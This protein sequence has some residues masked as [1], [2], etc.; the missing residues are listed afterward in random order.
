M[1]QQT[2][3]FA[4]EKGVQIAHQTFDG[5]QVI[6]LYEGV[7][8]YQ[9]QAQADAP[10]RGA[11]A[12]WKDR[13]RS[14]QKELADV[15]YLDA[16][17]PVMSP[18]MKLL[19]MR[20]THAREYYLWGRFGR[21]FTARDL[22]GHSLQHHYLVLDDGKFTA[23]LQA[24]LEGEF[25]AHNPNPTKSIAAV[26]SNFMSDRGLTWSQAGGLARTRAGRKQK[27]YDRK[28]YY[29]H[30]N[31]LAQRRIANRERL[32]FLASLQRFKEPVLEDTD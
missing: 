32:A 2:E 26:F 9:L 10:R 21:K 11:S 16:R 4:I 25:W 12:G 19:L 14:Y 13:F 30:T 8:H 6:V 5:G 18:N 31:E 27:G 22:F 7:Q 24:K 3:E 15:G 17:K 1:T 20:T 28:Y 23:H 29:T